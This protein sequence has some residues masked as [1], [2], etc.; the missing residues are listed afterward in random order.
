M[1][2]TLRAMD[3]PASNLGELVE[4]W[5][6]GVAIDGKNSRDMLA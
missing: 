5:G 1:M 3:A 6:A 4:E 2:K